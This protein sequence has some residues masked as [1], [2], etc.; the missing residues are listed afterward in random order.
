MGYL[1]ITYD[2]NNNLTYVPRQMKMAFTLFRTSCLNGRKKKKKAR[3]IMRV[4]F[5]NVLTLKIKIR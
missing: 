4:L 1:F 5:K 2:M 3:K